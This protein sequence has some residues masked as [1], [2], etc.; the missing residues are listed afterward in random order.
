MQPLLFLAVR[1][2]VNGIR[3][4]LTS[5]RRL[6]SLILVG[7]Y[8][9]W[10]LIR[11]A[12][13]NSAGP[14]DAA[15]GSLARGH[16]LAVMPPLTYIESAVFWVFA[17]ITGLLMLGS[18]QRSMYR[19]A[20]VDVLFPTPV[21]PRHVMIFRLIR[22][23]TATLI[24]PLFFALIGIRPVKIGF[25]YLIENF[26]E[27]TPIALRLMIVS[28]LLLSAMW[29]FLHYAIGLWVNRSDDSGDRNKKILQWTFGLSTAVVIAIAFVTGYQKIHTWDQFIRFTSNPVFHVYFFGAT[30]ATK[31]V[32][33]PLRGDWGAVFLGVGSIVGIGALGLVSA[34]RQVGWLYEQAAARAAGQTNKS[35]EFARKGDMM[36]AIAERA[37]QGKV[38][39]RQNRIT[40]W[41]APGPLALIWRDL[42]IQMRSGSMLLLMLAMTVL[43]IFFIY[44]LASTNEA[45]PIMLSIA[46]VSVF[47]V[48]M[49]HSQ[50][51]AFEM[52]RRVDCTKPMPFRPFTMAFTEIVGA[53][54]LPSVFGV[55]PAIA[56]GVFAPSAWEWSLAGVV[57]VP[58]VGL[59]VCA[60]VYVVTLLFPD[61]DDASQRGFRGLMTMLGIALASAPGVLSMIGVSLIFHLPLVGA[62]LWAGFNLGVIFLLATFAGTLYMNFNPNE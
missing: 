45:G 17:A 12:L 36:G 42:V 39:V 29:V 40:R 2:F 31:I 15:F 60:T 46:A 58:T 57:A 34:F 41:N 23:Y 26:P 21:D 19:Q 55:I 9:F 24:V 43:Y 37:R 35:R 50:N 44:Q 27:Q 33:G 30:A 25:K 47:A 13:I 16:K 5:G 54:L 51:H 11:P 10:I 32:M 22:D 7:G 59:L 28:W 48:T 3:R 6:V 4:A 18:Q 20:D 14:S 1:S 52:L 56:V 53:A 38:R 62:V 49:G 61:V 8:W